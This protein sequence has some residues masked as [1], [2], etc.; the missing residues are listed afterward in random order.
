MVSVFVTGLKV[1]WFKP[2][3][4]DGYLRAKHFCST[5]SFGG[6]EKPEAP[7]CK[8]LGNVKIIYK[9]E[10]KYFSKLKS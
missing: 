2:G 8:I 3:R 6:E 10:Q 7:C 1:R 9:H 5:P 4:G